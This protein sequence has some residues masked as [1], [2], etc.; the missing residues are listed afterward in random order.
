MIDNKLV[1][2]L[3][4]LTENGGTINIHRTGMSIVMQWKGP[5]KSG[6]YAFPAE[7]V[8]AM[9]R[10]DEMIAHRLHQVAD[11]AGLG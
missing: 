3:V 8:L 9:P 5:T 1:K 7:S 6:G 4:L 10:A 11:D 2:A